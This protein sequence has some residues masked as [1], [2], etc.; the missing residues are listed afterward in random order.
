MNN[1]QVE[2]RLSGLD[3]QSGIITNL[4][5]TMNVEINPNK[6]RSHFDHFIKKSSAC[7]SEFN[8]ALGQLE[9]LVEYLKSLDLKVIIK[10]VHFIKRMKDMR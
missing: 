9:M 3:V 10:V 4:I 5:N 2:K 6:L 7:S 1:A 8:A